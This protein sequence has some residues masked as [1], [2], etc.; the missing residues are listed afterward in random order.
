MPARPVAS[1]KPLG[2][3]HAQLIAELEKIV[4]EEGFGGFTVSDLAARLSC[5]KRTLYEIAPSKQELVL[6]VMDRWLGR[7][8]E[9]GRTGSDAHDDPVDRIDAYLRPGVTESRRAGRAFLEDLQS[10]PPA[11]ALLEAHQRERADALKAILKDGIARGRFRKLHPQFVADIFL[12]SVN[13]I[14]EPAVLESAHLSFSEAFAEFFAL[15]EH[16][17]VADR[18]ATG[19]GR[20][21][22]KKSK[23]PRTA[24]AARS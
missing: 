15:I 3:R 22:I 19:A 14:N 16:G 10:C 23:T 17:I 12:A 11:L 18:A 2:E 4:L 9:M 21:A 20:R 24:R 1:P 6:I 7:I 8:R 13:R 5:S